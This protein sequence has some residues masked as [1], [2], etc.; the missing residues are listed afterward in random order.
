MDSYVSNNYVKYVDLAGIMGLFI[1]VDL[2]M[3]EESGIEN[4]LVGLSPQIRHLLQHTRDGEIR[5]RYVVMGEKGG[6]TRKGRQTQCRYCEEIFHCRP[7]LINHQTRVHPSLPVR[8]G[9]KARKPCPHCHK[10]VINL[11]LHI[12]NKHETDPVNTS[13]GLAQCRLCGETYPANTDHQSHCRLSPVCPECNKTFSQWRVMNKHRKIVHMGMKMTCPHCSKTYHDSQSLKKHIDAVHLKIKRLC[14][15]CGASVTALAVH[16]NSVHTG[17]KNFPCPECGKK[18]KSN[19]DL[20]RHRDT[21]HLGNKPCCPFCGK[22]LANIRQH[23]RVVHKQIRFPCTICKKQMTTKAELKK[24]YAKCHYSMGGEPVIESR[25]GNPNIEPGENGLYSNN[26]LHKELSE[27]QLIAQ[28]LGKQQFSLPDSEHNELVI[29]PDLDHLIAVQRP[30]HHL[31][32]KPEPNH[33]HQAISRDQIARGQGQQARNDQE[34]GEHNLSREQLG[35]SMD[36]SM[37]REHQLIRGGDNLVLRNDRG[38]TRDQLSRNSDELGRHHQHLPQQNHQGHGA[39]ILPRSSG[40]NYSNGLEKYSNMDKYSTNDDHIINAN[41][42]FWS[43]GP[44][45]A[46]VTCVPAQQGATGVQTHSVKQKQNI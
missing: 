27:E 16:M 2:A 41:Q 40:G 24:H 46:S 39:L 21:V 19:Y 42:Q 12:R 30:S 3:I 15:L 14:P 38:M 43:Q 26:S 36:H 4:Y 34:R 32:L 28:Y 9:K 5:D 6:G 7:D 33:E 37:P 18:F 10:M 11:S 13:D 17:V 25:T 45:L 31:Q 35:I 8:A 44:P 20:N 1:K 22:H 23:I 29:K